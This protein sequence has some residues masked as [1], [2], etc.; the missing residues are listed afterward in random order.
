VASV[1]KAILSGST[2]PDAESTWSENSICK[3]IEWLKL[4]LLRGLREW[5]RFGLGACTFSMFAVFVGTLAGWIQQNNLGSKASSAKKQ[6]LYNSWIAFLALFVCCFHHGVHRAQGS[7]CRYYEDAVQYISMGLHE[8]MIPFAFMV[9][10]VFA[11]ALTSIDL[12]TVLAQPTKPKDSNFT[13]SATIL[14]H[15]SIVALGVTGYFTF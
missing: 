7:N 6:N 10:A 4:Q 11:I 9:V 1:V 8:A 14:G 5:W 3:I 12:Q 2:P 13:F 15:V